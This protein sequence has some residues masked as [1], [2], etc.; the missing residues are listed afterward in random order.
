MQILKSPNIPY[1]NPSLTNVH[2][3]SLLRSQ[4]TTAKIEL[5]D[6]EALIYLGAPG[7]HELQAGFIDFPAVNYVVDANVG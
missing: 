5:Q 2:L 1:F 4:V 6:T 3:C 7:V